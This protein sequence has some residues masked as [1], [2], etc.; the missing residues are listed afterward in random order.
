MEVL[1]SQF[2]CSAVLALF[3]DALRIL[4]R[5][6][7]SHKLKTEH[8]ECGLQVWSHCQSSSEAEANKQKS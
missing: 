3:H 7:H 1:D 2:D 4:M 6:V 8:C 5:D